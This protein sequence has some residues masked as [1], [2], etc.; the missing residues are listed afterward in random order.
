MKSNL[1]KRMVIGIAVAIALFTAYK[2]FEGF[3]LD[4]DLGDFE[5]ADMI[6]AVEYTEDGSQI[7]YF[8][9]DG[10]KTVIPGAEPGVNDQDPVW[11]PD[12]QRIFFV[13]NRDNQPYNIFRWNPAKEKVEQRSTGSQSKSS[14]YFGPPGWPGVENSALIISRG[15]VLE[16]NQRLQ[17]TWQ[18]LPPVNFEDSENPDAQSAFDALYGRI[19][20]SFKSAMWGVGRKVIFAVMRREADEVFIVNYME[21]IG[22]VQTGPK[23]VFAADTIQFDVGSDGTVVVSIRGFQFPDLEQI[24]DEFIK[25]GVA[26]KPYTNGTFVLQIQDDGT[27]NVYALELARADLGID[28]RELTSEFRQEHAIP[29]VIN[30]VFV[31]DTAEGYGGDNIGMKAGDVILSINDTELSIVND[32]FTALSEVLIGEPVT[33]RYYSG[34]EDAVVL[35]VTYVFGQEPTLFLSDPA[36]SPDSTMVAVVLGI[37][38]KGIN[39]SARELVLIP[40]REGGMLQSLRLIQGSV[41]E[42]SWHPDGKSLVYAKSGPSGDSQLFTINADGSNEKLVYGIGDYGRP[43]F[44]PVIR[45]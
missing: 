12:G 18:K 19:G 2:L 36:I 3:T 17:R 38:E 24:P 4:P 43:S 22:D 27:L 15:H 28:A 40:L 35:E 42:P 31:N 23:P 30:G 32:M 9:A 16:F 7:V 26:Y 10:K 13:S 33:I 8:D 1:V 6:V 14:P 44:S 37:I 5:S 34:G 41:F 25:K 20:T 21:K 11:R 39:F 29:D 45:K